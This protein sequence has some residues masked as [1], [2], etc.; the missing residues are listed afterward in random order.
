MAYSIYSQVPSV[1]GSNLPH[2]Q[3]EEVPW[4]DHLLTEKIY[5]APV[6]LVPAIRSQQ[7]AE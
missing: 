4:R 5:T 1:P 3:L 6:P 7:T 2:P